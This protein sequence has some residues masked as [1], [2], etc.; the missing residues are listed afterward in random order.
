MTES[1]AG[2]PGPALVR[3]PADLLLAVV[4]LVAAALVV[5]VVDALPVGSEELANDVSRWLVHIPR[6]LSFG[7]EVVAGCGCI[8]LVVLAVVTLLRNEPRGAVNAGV[9]AAGAFVSGIAASALWH[10]QLG[11]LPQTVFHGRNPS[12][13]VVLAT[14]IAFLT[15]SDLV[16]RSRWERWCVVAPA[17]LIVTGLAV[18]TLTLFAVGLALSGGLFWGWA[19]RWLDGA[20][21]VRPGLDQLRSWLSQSQVPVDELVTAD[22]GRSGRLEGTLVDGSVLDVRIANRDTRGSGLARRLWAIARL[23]PVVSGHL[24]L[25]SRSQLERLAL[26]GYVAHQTGILS[27]RVLLLKEEG[28]D[29]L[30]LALAQPS[31]RPVTDHCDREVA[32]ELFAALRAAHDAGLA[33]RDLRAEVLLVGPGVAGF[34]SL[35]SALPGASEL[36]RRLDVA[37]LLTTLGRLLGPADAVQALRQGYRP[38]DE[39]AI[40][41]VLQPIALAPWG[42]SAMRGASG[43]LAEIRSELGGA[44]TPIPTT[45]LERFRWRTVLT[46]VALTL[47]AFLLIGQLSRVNLLG[48]LRHTNPWWFA[49]ALVGSAA[50]YLGAAVN[51]AAFVPKRL[52][53][54]RGF[55]VQLSTAF[56]GLAMPPTVGHVA[57]NARYLRR[58]G[59]DASS[60]GAAVAL[61]QIVNIVSSLILLLVIGLLTGSGISRFHIVPSTDVLIGVGAIV[62]VFGVLL[63]IR[64]TRTLVSSHV[65]PRLQSLWPRLLQ[66]VSQ[67][68]RLAAG[69]G[70][71]LLLT[72]GY[73][74]AFIAALRAIGAHPALLPAAAVYLAGNAVGSAAPTPGG[75]GA[76]EAVLSAGLTAI[77]IPA[78][79]AIPAVLVFR[80]ATF[81][82]PIPAGWVAF[83]GLER[84]KIL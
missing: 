62:I 36:I 18:D 25:T 76:V 35:D 65:V 59:V 55:F 74:V 5:G 72:L 9:A 67:P 41:S 56:V 44:D 66:A 71:N 19:V 17:A 63:L 70:G 68:A 49:L 14:F 57:V 54:V 79:Q 81:W 61:S 34:S 53:M 11:P 82:L 16:R 26:A 64:P 39:A 6:W 37:Q 46:A 4:A 23:R 38:S 42:W 21:S 83:I 52:S 3:R 47:A 1:V 27:P 8:A 12:L 7:T 20:T 13:F 28:S 22:G 75:L 50:T 15:A 58:Q 24:S 32:R 10:G 78:H 30:L 48:A 31:G 51:L 29:T 43:C 73:L 84:R 33:H 40:V 45:R 77:G 80:V 2:E 60:I 69:I